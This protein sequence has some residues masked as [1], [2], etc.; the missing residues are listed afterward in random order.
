MVLTL[1]AALALGQELE[2]QVIDNRQPAGGGLIKF[3]QEFV[4]LADEA[5]GLVKDFRREFPGGLGKFRK[6]VESKCLWV[7]GWVGA[8]SGITVALFL[9][10]VRKGS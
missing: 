10:R 6:D 2:A 3:P 9:N 7:A 4:W 8:I 1:L 5:R